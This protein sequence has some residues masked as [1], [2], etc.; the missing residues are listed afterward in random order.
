MGF[1][2]GLLLARPLTSREGV[3]GV[4]PSLQAAVQAIAG[5]V[6]PDAV[7]IARERHLVYMVTWY[8]G[9]PCRLRAEPVPPER[10]WRLLLGRRLGPELK[11]A[12]AQARAAGRATR[13]LGP[14]DPFE[15]VLV[16]ESTWT[17]VLDR[18]EPA[19]RAR[20]EAWRSL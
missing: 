18:L 10:R 4:H 6:P 20:Y 11:A 13:S 1:A 12:L 5:A 14:R 17:W 2:C 8:T 9:L 7:V 3:V 15:L 16:P 19:A